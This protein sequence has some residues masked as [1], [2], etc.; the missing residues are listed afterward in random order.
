MRK[1]V[2]EETAMIDGILWRFAVN[3]I[4][5]RYEVLEYCEGNFVDGFMFDSYDKARQF[6]KR[7]SK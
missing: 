6:I 7:N 4:K 2:Y 3:Q 1:L 5:G